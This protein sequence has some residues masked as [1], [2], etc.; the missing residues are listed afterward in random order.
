MAYWNCGKVPCSRKSVRTKPV[1]RA[2]PP[3]SFLC[4]VTGT[5]KVS[6]R[7]K[8]KT[9]KKEKERNKGTRTTPDSRFARQVSS[10]WH[11]LISSYSG[12]APHCNLGSNVV[13]FLSLSH[14]DMVK[15]SLFSLLC[16][17]QHLSYFTL[18]V[19]EVSVYIIRLH[20][21]HYEVCTEPLFSILYGVP[22]S[23]TNRPRPSCN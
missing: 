7:A 19:S 6:G 11:P 12:W 14:T 10:Y 8:G 2:V 13:F 15:N 3:S 18:R 16:Q 17:V 4:E 5:R 1:I 21:C 23:L 9:E 20:L 22:H